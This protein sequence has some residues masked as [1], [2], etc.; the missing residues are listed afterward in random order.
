MTQNVTSGADGALGADWRYRRVSA[1]SR[2]S[3]SIAVR[4]SGPLAALTTISPPSPLALGELVVIAPDQSCVLALAQQ[5][6]QLVL[7]CG[8]CPAS[9]AGGIANGLS[10]RLPMALITSTTG[11]VAR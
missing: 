1:N 10:S 9:L 3:R 4:R 11:L 5:R 2:A 7:G 8:E 6:A